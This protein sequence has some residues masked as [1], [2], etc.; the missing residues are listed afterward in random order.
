MFLTWSSSPHFL[1][2]L[3]R[4]ANPIEYLAHF[5]LKNNP[6]NVSLETALAAEH[7]AAAE[8]GG[9][10]ASKSASGENEHMT[11]GSSSSSSASSSSS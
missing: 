5:L 4:P 6:L 1:L 7:E 2:N 3:C 9:A 11:E 10:D 8:G